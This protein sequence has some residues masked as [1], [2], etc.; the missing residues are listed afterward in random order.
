MIS[1][2]AIRMGIDTPLSLRTL[3]HLDGLLGFLAARRGQ[4]P[5]DIPLSR[6]EGVWQGS[7]A[8]L[9]TGALGATLSVQT[10][11]KHVSSDT[12][13]SGTFEHIEPSRRK[14][15]PMSPMRNALSQYPLLQGVRGVWFIGR[16][17]SARVEDLLRDARNLGAMGG[18]GYGRVI[19]LDLLEARDHPLTG[20]ATLTGMPVR[21]L[22]VE[23]WNLLGLGRHPSAVISLQR[24]YPPY[25]TGPS[26]PCI[27]P[28]QI[29]MTGTAREI[30]SLAAIV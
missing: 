23:T 12:V 10:R 25:W 21:T 18:T 11:V 17:D 6:Y 3:L 22:P 4:D 28:L 7:A 5:R 1:S 26:V 2:F 16:G 20:V 29:E 8:M 19:K 27:S 15:G 30:R 9:E 24:P 13:S 14:I